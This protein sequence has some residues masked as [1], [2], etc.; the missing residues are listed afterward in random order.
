MI[1][2]VMLFAIVVLMLA[3]FCVLAAKYGWTHRAQIL[4]PA[5]GALGL[6]I[7]A[8]LSV[9]LIMALALLFS[10]INLITRGGIASLYGYLA[11]AIYSVMFLFVVVSLFV[12]LRGATRR[13]QSAQATTGE[14]ALVP[15][16]PLRVVVYVVLVLMLICIAMCLKVGL[17]LVLTLTGFSGHQPGLAAILVAMGALVGAGLA[18]IVALPHSF[19]NR[20]L[21]VWLYGSDVSPAGWRTLRARVLGASMGVILVAAMAGVAMS[22]AVARP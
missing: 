2:S 17:F 11:C 15:I 1:S 9:L 22:V 7:R 18:A 21:G 6:A 8:R 14:H 3:G 16:S 19:L 4:D 10:L 12:T 5:A 20:R 13:R